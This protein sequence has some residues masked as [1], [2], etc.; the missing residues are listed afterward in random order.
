MSLSSFYQSLSQDPGVYI[1]QDR[2]G[3]VLYVGKAANLKKRVS[4]YFKDKALGEKTRSLLSQIAKVKTVIVESEIESLL[5]EANFIQKYKPKYNVKFTDGKAYPLI[6]IT[7][8]DKFPKVLMGRRILDKRSIYFGPFPNAGALRLVLK[9]IRRIFPFQGVINHPK[10]PC[11][12]YHLGLCPCPE[13]F[14]DESYRKSINHIVNFLNGKTKKVIKDLEKEREELSK[15]LE[16]EKAKFIQKKI[17]AVKLVTSPFFK[18]FEYEENPNL[19]YDLRK[20]ELDDLKQI[21]KNDG[22]NL[23][24]L[25]KIE[26]F[27]ISNFQGKEAAG[28]MIVFVNGE[29]ETSRYRRFKIR[30]TDGRPND[31]LMMSEV[32]ERRFS[33][34]EWEFPDLIV[35]D[36]GK[37]QVSAASFVLK[38]NRIS[39][40]VI[41]LAKREETIITQKLSQISLPKDS[42]SLHLLMRIRD[43]A[44]RFAIAYHKK[45]RGNHFLKT[46]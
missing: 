3:N 6:R 41:G 2:E 4:S 24:K 38:Q 8:K 14:R 10:K 27:D 44:H 43:E 34:F 29:K 22:V 19:T 18:P 7:I 17:I 28:S 12:Y 16:F 13:V 40:P 42:K 33:H 31:T 25:K 26:C 9:T 15:S 35:V 30:K 37:G 32:L 46:S 39:I 36:G 23:S 11:L 20:K 21:L 45:L 1:F 5:L